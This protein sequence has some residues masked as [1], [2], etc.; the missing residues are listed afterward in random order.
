MRLSRKPPTALARGCI[1]LNIKGLEDWEI[2]P[3]ERPK[4]SARGR[5]TGAVRSIRRVARA[6]R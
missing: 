4:Q 6:L 3:L 2:P 5:V 1:G